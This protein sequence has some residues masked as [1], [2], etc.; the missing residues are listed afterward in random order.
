MFIFIGYAVIAIYAGLWKVFEKARVPGWKALIPVYNVV[1]ILRLTGRPFYWLFLLFVPVVNIVIG[2]IL[3]IETAERFH[4]GP[5]FGA[6]LVL[7]PFIFF[8]ILG[9]GTDRYFPPET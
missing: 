1:V 3:R 6:G 9:F 5:V 8:P 7:L 4:K 2:V